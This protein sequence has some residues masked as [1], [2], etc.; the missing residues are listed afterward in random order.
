MGKH[1]MEILLEGRR[2][3]WGILLNQYWDSTLSN[4]IKSV[5][6]QHITKSF[7]P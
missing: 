5:L 7:D 1:E 4:I 2:R 6:R 3:L